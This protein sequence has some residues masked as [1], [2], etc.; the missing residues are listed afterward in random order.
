MAQCSFPTFPLQLPSR[1]SMSA[2]SSLLRDLHWVSSLTSP[3]QPLPAPQVQI[4]EVQIRC[5][6][7]ISALSTISK[8]LLHL[9]VL[10]AVENQHHHKDHRNEARCSQQSQ[11]KTGLLPESILEKRPVSCGCRGPT[12]R[13]PGRLGSQHSGEASRKHF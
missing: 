12:S 13:P 9:A 11:L 5:H 3:A 8:F 6:L 1:N 7:L 10:Q 4:C 2:F